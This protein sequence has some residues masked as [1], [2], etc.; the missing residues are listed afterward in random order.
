MQ[1]SFLMSVPV[2]IIT[3]AYNAGATISRTIES[4]LYQTYRQIE[5]IVIDGASTDDTLRKIEAFRD[6]FVG[7]RGR[8][9]RIISEPDNGMYD[10]LNKGIRLASGVLIGS[11]NADDWYEPDAVETMVS[12]Y[13]QDFYDVAW[14]D[15]RILIRTGEVIKRAFVGKRLWTTAGFCHPSMFATKEILKEFPYACE[16]MYDDFDFATRVYLQKRRI[17]TINKVI[18]NFTFG[19]MSNTKNWSDVRKRISLRYYGYR[20]YGMSR[21]YWFYCVAMELAKYVLG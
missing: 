19:G 7:E 20:K 12:L 5:Y 18:A 1:N 3:V 6:R 2:T 9:L 10:A 8:T 15:L 4:V 16:N 21:L 14:G 11:I 17:V 13:K